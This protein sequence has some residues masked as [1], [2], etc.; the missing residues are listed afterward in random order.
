VGFTLRRQNALVTI[1]MTVEQM[2]P[3]GTVL[4]RSIETSIRLRNGL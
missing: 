4:Q 2:G 3:D 1:W